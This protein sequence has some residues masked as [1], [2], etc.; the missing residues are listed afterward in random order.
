MD[1]SNAHRCIIEIQ[2]LTTNYKPVKHLYKYQLREVA[3]DTKPTN[4]FPK[5]QRIE[6]TSLFQDFKTQKHS[7]FQNVILERTSLYTTSFSSRN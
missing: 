7:L 6:A 5:Y 4:H 3:S 2:V 1:T